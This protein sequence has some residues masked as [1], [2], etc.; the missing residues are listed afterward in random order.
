MGV[1]GSVGM[2]SA[3][4]AADWRAASAL[5]SDPISDQNGISGRDAEGEGWAVGAGV[6]SAEE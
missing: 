1:S 5:K 2:A 4:L 3:A 6:G